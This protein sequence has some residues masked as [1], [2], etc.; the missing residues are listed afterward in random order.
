MMSVLSLVLFVPVVVFGA[1]DGKGLV[2]CDGTTVHPCTWASLYI[3]A[4]KIL[5][6]IVILSTSVAAIVFAWAG[7]LYFS[8]GGDTG[9]IQKAHT[10]FRAVAIGLVI[11]LTAWLVV[12]VL[13]KTLTDKGL[14][15]RA[16]EQ[17]LKK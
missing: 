12:D 8:A 11:I 5:N 7:V 16:T 15:Q 2:P 14:D 10:L 1:H 6:F 3:L 4:G 9:K 13:L 17:G